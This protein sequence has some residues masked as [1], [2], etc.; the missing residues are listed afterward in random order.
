MNIVYFC[1]I[2]SYYT[3]IIYYTTVVIVDHVAQGHTE[4]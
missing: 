2:F 3:F 4:M 1:V